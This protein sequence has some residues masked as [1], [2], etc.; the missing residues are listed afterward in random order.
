MKNTWNAILN[1]GKI[2]KE[3]DK[4]Y[5]KLNIKF[6]YPE[7]KMDGTLIFKDL[8]IEWKNTGK[9]MIVFSVNGIESEPSSEF[10]VQDQPQTAESYIVSVFET[11]LIVMTVVT[12]LL[13]VT[14]KNHWV[15]LVIGFVVAATSIGLIT[16]S[17]NPLVWLI[18]VWITLGSILLIMIYM[19]VNL[20]LL[21]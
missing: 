16:L 17:E 20:T 10:D 19:F 1:G 9:F 4:N 12:M 21:K 15:F 3:V 6:S 8:S 14:A 7:E 18:L 13:G 5:E 11:I 2:I